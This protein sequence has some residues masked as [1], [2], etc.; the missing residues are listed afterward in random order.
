MVFV[1]VLHIIKDK[2]VKILK[3]LK[4]DV[5][6]NFTFLFACLLAVLQK[7]PKYFGNVVCFDK[8]IETYVFAR[9]LLYGNRKLELFSKK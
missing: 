3:N 4:K 6:V 9:F 8:F 7:K 1:F 2:N 5:R